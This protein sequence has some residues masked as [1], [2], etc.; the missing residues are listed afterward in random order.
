MKYYLDTEF[1][2]MDGELISLALVGEDDKEL[3]LSCTPYLHIEPD[4]WVAKNVLP[5]LNVAS[6]K[7][8]YVYYLFDIGNIIAE[9]LVCDPYP[10]IIADWPV[11]VA[12]F[13][14]TLIIGPGQMVNIRHLQF[15]VIRVD[16]YPT[17]LS[18]AVQHNALWDA[19]ALRHKI[20]GF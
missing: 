3:Y 15:Q 18:N 8:K 10:V 2:G 16:A 7:P 13:C 1:N 4:P 6:A 5:V 17:T 12:H 11:D 19:R 14:K 20:E 9:F